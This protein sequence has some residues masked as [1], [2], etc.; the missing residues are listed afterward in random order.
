LHLTSSGA[1]R[2][3][4]LVLPLTLAIAWLALSASAQQNPILG[5]W[6]LTSTG[7]QP[8]STSRRTPVN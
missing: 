3:G 4:G 7:E 2:L 6:S 8:T 5:R 1:I